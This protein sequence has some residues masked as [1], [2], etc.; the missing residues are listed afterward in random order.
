MTESDIQPASHLRPDPPAN[1]GNRAS[2]LWT[3]ITGRWELRPDELFVL[4]E[5]CREV[6]LIE[7]MEAHQRDNGLIG[8]GSMGQP[9][10]APMIAELRQHR[11]MVANLLKA[12][13]LPDDSPGASDTETERKRRGANARW[14]RGATGF[15]S[16]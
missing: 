7:R 5:A 10:A 1:L 12:L 11:A 16:A 2:Q 15:G 9:V 4:T 8:T 13:R 14:G 3:D 6:D